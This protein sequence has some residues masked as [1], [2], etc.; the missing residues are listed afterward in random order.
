MWI[1]PRTFFGGQNIYC[2]MLKFGIQDRYSHSELF[3]EIDRRGGAEIEFRG[4]C[5]SEHAF[6]TCKTEQIGVYKLL[7]NFISLARTREI[8]SIYIILYCLL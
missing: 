8:N 5:M 6:E 2:Q 7:K 4:T 1:P 3:N